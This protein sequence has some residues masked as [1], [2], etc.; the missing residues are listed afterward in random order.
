[1]TRQAARNVGFGNLVRWLLD[2][3]FLKGEKDGQLRVK[4]HAT[5]P[6]LGEEALGTVRQRHEGR[7]FHLQPQPPRSQQ[8][9]ALRNRLNAESWLQQQE[10]PS[11]QHSL[12]GQDLTG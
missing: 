12:S 10:G 1:M 11:S 6:V 7:V 4:V 3:Y 9:L 5:L 2:F 8:E